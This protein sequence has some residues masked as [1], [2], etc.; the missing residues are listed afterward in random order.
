[1]LEH[2]A[3]TYFPRLI[4]RV[5][6]GSGL[7]AIVAFISF[8]GWMAFNMDQKAAA[9]SKLLFQN[10]IESDLE[11]ARS[12]A[13]FLADHNALHTGVS[14]RQSAINDEIGNFVDKGKIVDLLYVMKPDGTPLQAFQKGSNKSDLDLYAH[15]IAENMRLSFQR[16]PPSPNADYI[17]MAMINGKVY[18][19]TITRA[20]PHGAPRSMIDEV[21]LLITG[22]P[23]DMDRMAVWGQQM[24][25]SHV[26]LLGPADAQP[27]NTLFIP[28]LDADRNRIA[29]LSW[30]PPQPGWRLMK[31]S[32][33]LIFGVVLLV[34]M[35]MFV[36]HRAASRQTAAY[37]LEHERARTD[38]LTGLLNRKGLEERIESEAAQSALKDGEIALIYLDLNEFKALNDT[39]G[40]HAGDKALKITAKRLKSC[41]RESDLVAR[42]GGDEFICVI[43]SKRPRV[44]VNDAAKRIAKC[45]SAPLNLKEGTAFARTAVGVAVAS[46]DQSWDALKHAADQAM[47]A[48]KDEAKIK[49]MGG[50]S[51]QDD[52]A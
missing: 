11:N 12:F 35:G 6:G 41:V 4:V 22:V 32:A 10:I 20:L 27:K 3:L 29:T 1:M 9:D 52:A 28:I 39:L 18:F 48:A 2:N 36:V 45:T 50:P 5:V 19:L 14:S 24:T 8:V 37:V 47:Y 17:T 49:N 26:S 13:H 21:P 46:K 33:P 42:L 30:P 44:S 25:I 23:L 15:T 16:Q 34:L 7:I 51:S 38:P 43:M 31:E 40:H